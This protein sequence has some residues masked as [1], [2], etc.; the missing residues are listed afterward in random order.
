MNMKKIFL[1]FVFTFFSFIF[2]PVFA[3]CIS[4][5]D[6]NIKFLPNSRDCTTSPSDRFLTFYNNSDIGS[7][8]D[9]TNDLGFMISGKNDGGY[10]IYF[11]FD[12][13]GDDP[14]TSDQTLF[15]FYDAMNRGNLVARA[16]L[17]SNEFFL[18]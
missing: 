4:L 12:R 8:S 17:R 14:I 18:K 1:S 11:T 10:S 2:N 16:G 6:V 3:S 5:S 7:Y 15:A 9:S 13:G